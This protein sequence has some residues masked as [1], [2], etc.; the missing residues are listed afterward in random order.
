G[1]RSIAFRCLECE[2]DNNCIIC[3]DCFFDS[4]HVGHRT[5]LIRTQGGACDC[6]DAG[7]WDPKGFC[8][9]HGRKKNDDA[10]LCLEEYVEDKE[11]LINDFGVLALWE[12]F[13]YE[14]ERHMLQI[15]EEISSWLLKR[16]R[17][18][19]G[20]RFILTQKLT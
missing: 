19:Y 13:Y 11:I 15:Q 1:K 4:N 18:A 10:F 8:S 20:F 9:K 5:M 12:S 16:C 2:Y 14:Q 6:G 7:S 3:P 17:I